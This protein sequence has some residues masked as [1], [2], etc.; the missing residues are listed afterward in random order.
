VDLCIPVISQSVVRPAVF[1][2]GGAIA[3]ELVVLWLYLVMNLLASLHRPTDFFRNVVSG[4]R[5]GLPYKAWK[6]LPMAELDVLLTG[7]QIPFFQEALADPEPD[8]QF[9]STANVLCGF[10]RGSVPPVHIVSGWYDFFLRGSIADFHRARKAGQFDACLTIGNFA[11]W[12]L[13]MP[14][15][16]KIMYTC[17]LGSLQEVLCQKRHKDGDDE[18]QR[19]K[20]MPST[21]RCHPVCIQLINSGDWLQMDTWPP[22][23][24]RA[25]M[26]LTADQ[27]L[28]W[29][30]AD[31]EDSRR[32]TIDYTYDASRPTPSAGGPSFSLWNAGSKNQFFIER[33]DR[34]D[35]VLFTAP[36]S[37]AEIEVVGDVRAILYISTSATK[38]LDVIARLCS[39]SRLG[40]SHNICEGLTRVNI[41]EAT[42]RAGYK[43]ASMDN[44]L[45]IEVDLGPTAFLHQAGER[46]RLH[47]T[48]AA[49]PRWMRNVGET[50]IGKLKDVQIS[51]LPGPSE[52]RIHASAAKPSVLH[53]PLLRPY[54]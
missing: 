5:S 36:P 53:M 14:E 12:D 8:G 27:G 3:L 46:L 4:W 49:H 45:K 50:S 2:P 22:R 1:L 32:T 35:L 30:R 43:A 10:H 52:V 7:K 28:R 39:V 54:I 16:Q 48:S 44:V 17:S 34:T 19:T 42:N 15:P 37:E 20:Q 33:R 11:H 25:E 26:F 29:H 9:W 18:I 31:L 24:F 38:S 41:Q 47:V 21:S 23:S 6:S 40:F 13:L 51:D